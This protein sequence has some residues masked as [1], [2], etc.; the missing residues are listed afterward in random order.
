VCRVKRPGAAALA[1]LMLAVLMLAAPAA[2]AGEADV[3]GAKVA[4]RGAGVYDFDVT[5]RSR[6]T[7]WDR[8]ADRIE[9]VGPDGTVLGSRALHHPHDDEQPFTRDVYGLR[10]P[11]GIDRVVVRVHFKPVGFAGDTMVVRLP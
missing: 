10:I 11:P 4:H 6:D 2:R 3:V 7:G 9:I 8:Y 1:M 5:V